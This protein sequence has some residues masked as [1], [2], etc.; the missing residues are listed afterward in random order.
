MLDIK[1]GSQRKDHNQQDVLRIYVMTFA[2]EALYLYYT[3]LHLTVCGWYGCLVMYS[4]A[5]ILIWLPDC[6]SLS[7]ASWYIAAVTLF[8]AG[9]LSEQFVSSHKLHLVRYNPI[10]V[11]NWEHYSAFSSEH[12]TQHT[13]WHNRKCSHR[14]RDVGIYKNIAFIRIVLSL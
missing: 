6:A 13:A 12:N 5:L 9:R 11:N 7:P 14:L 3:I 1:L 4:D 8:R 10:L 2:F